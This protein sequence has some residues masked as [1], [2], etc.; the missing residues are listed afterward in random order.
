MGQTS[1][2]NHV[3]PLSNAEEAVLRV[4][5]LDGPLKSANAVCARTPMA[6]SSVLLALTDLE[7]DGV[8][9]FDPERG[10]WM[11][12]DYRPKPSGLQVSYRRAVAALAEYVWRTDP[13]ETISMDYA[14]SVAEDVLR[15]ALSDRQRALLDERTDAPDA[16]AG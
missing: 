7:R 13:D 3:E 2:A 1:L 6:R 9:R 4:V 8:L 14:T 12:P 11:V 5:R 10:G 16:R 15:A